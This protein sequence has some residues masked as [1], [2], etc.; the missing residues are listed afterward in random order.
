[1]LNIAICDDLQSDRIHMEN[2]TRDFIDEEGYDATIIKFDSGEKLIQYYSNKNAAFDIVFLDIYMNGMNG[3]KS[4]EQIRKY[5]ADCKIIFTTSSAEHS[6]ESFKV[7]P[8]FY[9]VK[10]IDKAAFY[11][12]AE[13][14]VKEINREKR[15]SLSVKIG[16][17]IQTV[18]YKDI[19]FIESS[20]KI[21]SVHTS[22][23]RV[24]TYKFKLD[25]LQN[26][27]DDKRF[28]RCHK[29]FLVNM[30]QISGVDNYLFE[31]SGGTQ[32][33]I[34]QRT[35]ASIKKSFYDYIMD[36]ADLKRN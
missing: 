29:S 18:F 26:Q 36:K 20:A 28:L 13:K 9:L 4:A 23:D 12:V 33:P 5:D 10:P 16:S 11:P 3:L 8:F 15:K 30:D 7:F 35:F 32:I 6:L 19:V 25:E 1:M 2:L 22:D 21:L 31:L 34:T 27:I 17:S 14:A 24:I